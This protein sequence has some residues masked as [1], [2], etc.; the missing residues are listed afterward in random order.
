MAEQI[1]NIENA[2]N[3]LNSNPDRVVQFEEKYGVGSAKEVMDGTYGNIK[4]MD[5]G[6]K[7]VEKNGVKTYLS[8]DGGYATTDLAT[9]SKILKENGDAGE[10]SKKSFYKDVIDQAP[11]GLSTLNKLTENAFVV[12]EGIPRAA[13]FVSDKLGFDTNVG[14]NIR[15]NRK[16]MQEVYPKTSNTLKFAGAVGTAVPAV[17]ALLPNALRMAGSSILKRSTLGALGSGI[18]WAGEGAFQGAMEDADSFEQRKKNA[19]QRGALQGGFAGGFGILGPSFA[20]FSKPLLAKIRDF[21][22][23]SQ[24][25]LASKTEL[26]KDAAEYVDEIVSGSVASNKA[27]GELNT[28][29]GISRETMDVA[30]TIANSPGPGKKIIIDQLEANA[31]KAGENLNKELDIIMGKPD[32]GKASQK[33]NISSSTSQNR[34]NLYNEAYKVSIPWNTTT[35]NNLKQL[36]QKLGPEDITSSNKVS[37]LEGVA[38]IKIKENMSDEAVIALDDG[39]YVYQSQNRE[40]IMQTNAISKPTMEQLDMITRDLFGK[41]RALTDNPTLKNSYANMS[42]EIRKELDNINPSYKLARSSGQDNIERQLAVDL[43]S[44]IFKPSLTF[45]DFQLAI[46]GMSA[47]Q[48]DALKQAVRNRFDEMASNVKTRLAGTDAESALQAAEIVKSMSSKSMRQKLKL[49]LGEADAEKIFAAFEKSTNPLL[50]VSHI[51]KGSATYSRNA[52]NKMI[53]NLDPTNKKT[54]VDMDA[55]G[56]FKRIGQAGSEPD[57]TRQKDAQIALAKM[58]GEPRTVKDLNSQLDLLKSFGQKGRK[59]AEIIGGQSRFLEQSFPAMGRVV[60]SKQRE[61]DSFINT[62]PYAGLLKGLLN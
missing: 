60:G 32:G 28:I 42:A 36:M 39:W 43:G 38:P 18:G 51:K 26:N 27:A 22:P 52:Y 61:D 11:T 55:R 37:K 44:M 14:E 17:S 1:K 31:K 54:L 48:R 50:L 56:I 41:S 2:K 4:Y 21:F 9:I 8:G 3:W 59:D 20:H 58:L 34:K 15:L 30:D 23:K 19:I 49:V 5:D 16:A 13:Q 7:I 25:S 45:D 29:A 57:L 46:S 35:A 10:V 53:G 6:G 33:L 12:G 40:G 62:N 24:S 47:G